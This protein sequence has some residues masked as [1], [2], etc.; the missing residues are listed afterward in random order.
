MPLFAVLWE[1]AGPALTE[2]HPSG[3]GV[4]GDLAEMRGEIST[5]RVEG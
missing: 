2:L 3:L 4:E 1:T 5:P